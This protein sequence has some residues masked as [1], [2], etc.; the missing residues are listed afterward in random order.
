MENEKEINR[1]WI[2]AQG[3]L[4]NT[5]HDFYQMIWQRYDSYRMTHYVKFMIHIPIL[6]L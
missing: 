2:A 1:K 6:Y 5:V 4:P 3:P